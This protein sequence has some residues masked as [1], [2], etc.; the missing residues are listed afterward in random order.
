MKLLRK[1]K[2]WWVGHVLF[3]EDAEDPWVCHRCDEVVNY[4]TAVTRQEGVKGAIS[5]W[6]QYKYRWWAKCPA[7]GKRFGKCDASIDHLPF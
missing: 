6:F 7:C 3:H 4:H 1:L 5:D 2:C